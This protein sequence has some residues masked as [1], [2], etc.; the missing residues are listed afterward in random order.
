M[1]EGHELGSELISKPVYNCVLLFD[2]VFWKV[3]K[4]SEVGS[5]K[6]I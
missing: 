4:I 3:W 2:Y 5:I 6:Y 1:R